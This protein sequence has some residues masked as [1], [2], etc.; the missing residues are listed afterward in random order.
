MRLK[1]IILSTSLLLLVLA[2]GQKE[3]PPTASNSQPPSTEQIYQ[4]AEKLLTTFALPQD[5]SGQKGEPVK[6]VISPPSLTDTSYEIYSVT[7]IWGFPFNISQQLPPVDWS[8]TLGVNGEAVVTVTH[9]IDF[10]PGQDSILPH[11]AVHY[12]AWNSTTDGDF[13]GLNFLVF[14]KKG[15]LY[16]AEPVLT[17]DTEPFDLVLHFGQL[18]NFTALYLVDNFNVVAVRACRIWPYPCPRGLMVGEWVKDAAHGQTGHFSGLW[19]SGNG[20]TAGVF[21]G[22]FWHN[23]EEIGRF[24]G[25]VSGYYTDQVI[26][27]FEGTWYYDD[28]TMCPLCGTGRGFF[29]GTYQYT[30]QNGGG[31]LGG[32]FGQFGSTELVLPLKG[33]WRDDCDLVTS[34]SHDDVE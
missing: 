16:F 9:T 5:G 28:P 8:G 33:F 19:L 20:D 32:A 21:S 25:S 11:D 3:D 23:D 27:D 14:L 18:D 6:N 29:T 2:C 31:K 10:E 17:F 34:G 26:A 7:F 15:I 4:E 1:I 12:A 22:I 30:N 24:Q 13:D